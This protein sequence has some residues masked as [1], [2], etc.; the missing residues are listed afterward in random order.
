[1][2]VPSFQTGIIPNHLAAVVWNWVV[3]IDYISCCYITTRCTESTFCNSTLCASI[4]QKP[5]QLPKNSKEAKSAIIIKTQHR[6]LPQSGPFTQIL[7]QLC[8]TTLTLQIIYISCIRV[9]PFPFSQEAYVNLWPGG[10]C[11][12]VASNSK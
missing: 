2:Q 1:M 10:L 11:E 6:D 4:S 7:S 12:F 5:N 9:C 3:L 8:S